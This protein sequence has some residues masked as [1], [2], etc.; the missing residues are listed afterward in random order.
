MSRGDLVDEVENLR[1][2][3]AE[4]DD[5]RNRLAATEQALRESE[6]RFRSLFE[7]S[8]LAYQSLNEFGCYEDCND[9]LCRLLGCPKDEILGKS[10]DEFW[11]PARKHLF[12]TRFDGFKGSGSVKAEVQ[13]VRKDGSVVTVLLAGRVQ[14][15][16]NGRFVR[17]HCILQDITARTLAEEALRQA[18]D[19]LERRVTERTGKLTRS[20]EQLETGI[21]RLAQTEHELRESQERLELALQGAKLGLWDWDIVT[22]RIVRSPHCA[23][24]LGLEPADLDDTAAAWTDRLHPDDRAV[25]TGERDAH[26]E[27]RTPLYVAEYRVRTKSGDWRWVQSRGAVVERDQHGKPCRMTGVVVD[28]HDRRLAEL[29]LEK[30]RAELEHRIEERTALL[31]SANEQLQREVCEHRKSEEGL[32]NSEER[33][34]LAMEVTT[35]GVWDWNVA[36]GDIYRSPGFFSMLGYRKEEFPAGLSGFTSAIHPDD[37]PGILASLEDHLA[38]KS[39]TYEV[40]FRLAHKSEEW[41]WIL[42]RGKIVAR[43]PYGNPTRLVGTHTDITERKKAD[44]LL[45]RAEQRYRR[46]FEEAPIMYVITRNVQGVP[47]VSDC[48]ELF[49]RSV[50]WSREEVL[51]RPLTDFYAPESRTQLLEGGGYARALS[52]EFLIGERRLL[53]R[54]GRL[55]PTLV[56]TATESD[57]SGKVIGTRGMYVDITDRKNTEAAL[58]ESEERYRQITENSLTGILVFQDDRAVFANRRLSEMLGYSQDEMLS[59]SLL[60][61]IHPDDCN[62]VTEIA[63]GGMAGFRVPR[64]CEPRLLHKDGHAVWTEILSHRMD[65]QGRPAIIASVADVTER[66]ILEQQLRHSQKMEAVG[67][68]AGGIAHDFNNLLHIIGGHA[69][70][71]ELELA[72]RDMTFDETTAIRRAAQRGADL[73]KQILTFSRRIQPRPTSINLN[74]R[75]R[76]VRALLSPT[77]PKL[78]QI[79]LHLEEALAPVQ[80]DAAQIEQLLANLAV[81]ATDAM[82][83]GGN[84]R[85]ETHNVV[86]DEDHCRNHAELSPGSYVVLRV[87][88]TGRG[89]GKDALPHVFDP[90]FTTKGRADATGLGLATVF[91]IVKMHEGH[92]ICQSEVGKGTSFTIYF[93]VAESAEPPMHKGQG[94]PGALGPETVLVVDDEPL[95]RELAKRVLQKAG[96]SVLTADSG[97]EAI[98]TYARHSSA[99]SL[100]VLD[101]VMPEMGGRQCLDQ[102]LTI[103]PQVKALIASGFALKGDTKEFLDSKARGVVSKPFTVRELVAAV[104]RAIDGV[105]ASSARPSTAY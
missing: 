70:L 10:F 64:H 35:D 76:S 90:F 41:V 89:I 77:I 27:S 23:Q 88:D 6:A 53:T 85:I 42:S 97:K 4:L 28:I 52:G 1:R 19:E 63:E 43:D 58:K 9:E 66:R 31:S 101:L 15:D 18:K 44:E 25:L 79:D 67:I 45:R 98:E 71:L 74:D 96:Y 93:P 59:M 57:S 78:I 47:F 20:N 105:P 103:D 49:L 95:I 56:H 29:G 69:E 16:A 7:E 94:S 61:R 99:I 12:R 3:T 83:E 104:R 60:E 21:R 37:R 91:G 24:I 54:D 34:R 48:N 62:L 39:D 72:D 26:I 30:L 81:N 87:S 2:R 13:L 22:D 75:V 14:H 17:T 38:G 55:V 46:L 8:P 36:T 33:F 82:P 100:V 5:I 84:L 50:G 40:A 65:Y 102:L 80:A 92:I 73:V 51:G 68:L 86:L 32:R 11:T